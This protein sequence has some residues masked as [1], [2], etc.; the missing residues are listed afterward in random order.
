MGFYGA[1]IAAT[2]LASGH[3]VFTLDGD[4][5]RVPDLKL[6]KPGHPSHPKEHV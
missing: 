1:A 4:Y 3:T 5:D 6:I 2:A